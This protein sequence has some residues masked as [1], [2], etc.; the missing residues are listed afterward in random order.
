MEE[1]KKEIE[2]TKVEP[3]R[4]PKDNI[5]NSDVLEKNEKYF[6]LKRS[7]SKKSAIIVVL[8]FIIVLMAVLVALYYFNN[9]DKNKESVSNGGNNTPSPTSTVKTLTNDEA[10]KIAKEKLEEANIPNFI[11]N[12]CLDGKNERDAEGYCYFDTLENFKKKFYS[13][14]SNKIVY[15][16]VFIEYNYSN[17]ETSKG[18]LGNI[19]EYGIKD[20]NVYTSSC[21]IGGNGFIRF[22][23][24]SVDSNIEDKIVVKYNEVF[25]KDVLDENSGEEERDSVKITLIKENNDWKILNATIVDQCNGTYKVGKE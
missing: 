20:N 1:E 5:V 21:N 25:L 4:M 8:V 10:I 24:F 17:G 9:K 15:N 7:S 12:L 2:E 3:T 14:Y 23:N 22:G 13:V 16:D 11:G 6:E 19:P 18:N